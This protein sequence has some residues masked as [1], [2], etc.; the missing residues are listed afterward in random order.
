MARLSGGGGV[1]EAVAITNT[2]VCDSEACMTSLP[3]ARIGDVC[4]R[5]DIDETF[6]LAVDDPTV[7]G[8]W[9]ALLTANVVGTGSAGQVAVFDG[10]RSISGYSS[11]L[12]DDTNYNLS[13]GQSLS[14]SGTHGFAVGQG[15]TLQGTHN[16]LMGL[17]NSI[18]AG[19]HKRNIV[20]GSTL[21]A[22]GEDNGVFGSAYAVQ[23]SYNLTG[24]W[25]HGTVSGT[26]N[27]VAGYQNASPTGNYMFMAGQGNDTSSDHTLTV[28][29]NNQN[30]GQYS[31]MGGDTNVISSPYSF[32]FGQN[33]TIQTNSPHCGVAGYNNV[34]GSGG[35]TTGYSAVFGHDNA[36]QGREN[37]VGGYQHVIGN[38]GYQAQ[39]NAIFGYRMTANANG[40]I[41]AGYQN[42][43]A[44]NSHYSAVF[45]RLNSVQGR[46]LCGGEA[47]TATGAYHL[48]A[49]S[50]HE[51]AGNYGSALGRSAKVTMFG[52]NARATGRFS[53]TGD[54]QHSTL[55]GSANT[56][57]ATPTELQL[58]TSSGTN[59]TT[60]DD[61][62][63]FYTVKVVG[64]N[65]ADSTKTFMAELKFGFDRATG[66]ASVR[67]HGVIKTIL[68]QD[69]LGWDIN[70]TADTTNGRP[71]ILVTGQAGTTIHWSARI[72][73]VEVI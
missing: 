36:I 43:I 40:V 64:R 5:T 71:A 32:A 38:A 4:V 18:G 50:S 26:G 44:T 29:N 56:A 13:A 54:C 52:Q 3:D 69:T 14:I 67:L 72:D 7:V 51:L 6:I 41:M 27:L 8:N 23:G 70:V 12:Y 24:G 58:D 39:Y 57:D 65:T 15:H 60:E 11:Y 46:T 49:G 68:H 10:S 66:V 47:S 16:V 35:G 33:N 1:P 2:Y 48:I 55:H 20:G 61:K 42:T 31:V 17:N 45:G 25:N 21:S 73:T 37:I 34:V 62:A 53:A 22:S 19:N 59:L 30:D 28:G 9:V 63:Y